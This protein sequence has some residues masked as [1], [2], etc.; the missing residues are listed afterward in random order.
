[1][2]FSLRREGSGRSVLTNGK[3]PQFRDAKRKTV[4][5]LCSC[6]AIKTWRKFH[7]VVVQ[8]GGTAKKSTKK[9]DARAKLLLCLSKPIGFFA[10]SLPSPKLS[11]KPATFKLPG[12]FESRVWT[13]ENYCW[14]ILMITQLVE[15]SC[16]P[17]LGALRYRE[18]WAQR[19]R[20]SARGLL[21]FPAL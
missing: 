16:T 4:T 10:F 15:P 12:C 5:V 21:F 18:L 3:R 11:L 20:K 6:P 9:R 8:L 2:K 17:A 14:G 1:M 19:E 13:T 7:V